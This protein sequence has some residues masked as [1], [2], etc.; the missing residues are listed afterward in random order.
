MQ[1]EATLII[2]AG[3]QS[4]R[5]GRPKHLLPSPHGTLIDHHI[6]RLAH[7]FVETL[8]VGRGLRLAE[9]GFRIVED[10]RHEQCPLVGIYSGLRAANTD[11][12]FVLA[13][14]LPFVKPELVQYLLSSADGF[15]ITVPIV[16]GY[17]EPLCAVYRRT[18]IAAAEYALGAGA[19]KTTKIYDY[20]RLHPVSEREIRRFDPNLASF[21]NLNTP[22][23]LKLL[24]SLDRETVR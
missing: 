3:G 9:G 15:D 2:L 16:N 8:V 19:R 12:G 11:L 22:K 20:L 18:A 6:E 14:D 5:M 23:Q 17:Y 7:L 24:S 21:V 4:R 13:C 1:E 10:A